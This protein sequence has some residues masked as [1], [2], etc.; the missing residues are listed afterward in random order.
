M[1]RPGIVKAVL[2]FLFLVF[3]IPGGL[4]LY[5]HRHFDVPVVAGRGVARVV[6]L[7]DFGPGLKGTMADP[8]VYFLEGKE[9]GGKAILLS[10]TQSNEPDG[11]LATLLMLENAVVEKGTLIIIPEFNHSAGRNTRPGDGYPPH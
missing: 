9:P 4:Q 3:L 5:R 11:T 2:I 8:L 6:R 7:S 10:N 1:K